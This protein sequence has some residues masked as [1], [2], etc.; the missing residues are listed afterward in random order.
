MNGPWPAAILRRGH[1]PQR[2]ELA[3]RRAHIK[4]DSR[5]TTL[6]DR[7]TASRSISVAQTA[8]C[9]VP[10]ETK[11]PGKTGLPD[12]A[13]MPHHAG[14]IDEMNASSAGRRLWRLLFCVRFDYWRERRTRR[15]LGDRKAGPPLIRH[16]RLVAAAVE[17]DVVGSTPHGFQRANQTTKDGHR[18]R[19]NTTQPHVA[20]GI[21]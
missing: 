16:N 19:G 8:D 14:I 21:D 20:R 10:D 9:S 1:F 4:M 5:S 12:G 15:V 13:G 7:A 18:R 17:C 11:P 6:A 3:R 2:G